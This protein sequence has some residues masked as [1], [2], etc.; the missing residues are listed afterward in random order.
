MPAVASKPKG[1]G[2]DRPTF[3]DRVKKFREAKGLTRP[4][5]AGQVGVGVRIMES[6]EQGL[7]SPGTFDLMTRLADALG[8]TV[9][10]L[11]RDDPDETPLPRRG[12]GR[13]PKSPPPAPP[14][15]G[16]RRGKE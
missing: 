3:G 8:V 1:V 15:P 4:Q 9:D 5:L 16:R 7:R 6:W 2:M 14:R 12:P 10:D 11:I 13:P